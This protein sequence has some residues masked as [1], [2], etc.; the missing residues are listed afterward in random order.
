MEPIG[1]YERV[2]WYLLLPHGSV[3]AVLQVVAFVR[4]TTCHKRGSKPIVSPMP[5]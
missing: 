5:S 4:K 1:R 3:G 2:G